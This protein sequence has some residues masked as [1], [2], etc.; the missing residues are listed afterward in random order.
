MPFQ[1]PDYSILPTCISSITSSIGDVNTGLSSIDNE[2]NRIYTSPYLINNPTPK[3]TLPTFSLSNI[4][5]GVPLS[6]SYSALEE[7][8]KNACGSSIPSTSGLGALLVLVKNILEGLLTTA[9]DWVNSQVSMYVNGLVYIIENIDDLWRGIKISITTYLSSAISNFSNTSGIDSVKWS[10]LEN[11]FM[12][13]MKN[14]IKPLMT[15]IDTVESSIKA[16]IKTLEDVAKEI[17]TACGN[18]EKS[19][20]GWM[21]DIQCLQATATAINKVSVI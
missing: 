7:L 14:M 20:E 11:R 17:E 8:V 12:V 16:L 2:L 4:Q 18:I 13:T 15:L 5:S 1:L 3:P 21:G 19:I 9:T 6:P 10:E